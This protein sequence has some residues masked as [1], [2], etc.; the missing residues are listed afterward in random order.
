MSDDTHR[1]GADAG[2]PEDERPHDPQPEAQSPH[3][4]TEGDAPDPKAES[5]TEATEKAEAEAAESAKSTG[6]SSETPT[7][8]SAAAAGDSGEAKPEQS[9]HA[10]ETRQDDDQP[11]PVQDESDY[12]QSNPGCPVVGV[13]ASAG[14]LQAFSALLKRLP[15]NPGFAIVFVQHLSPEHESNLTQILSRATDL[16]VQEAADGTAIE[17]D[18]VYVIPPNRD[19]AVIQGKLQLMSRPELAAQ[20]MPVDYLFRSMADDLGQRAIGVVLSGTGTDG[21][22]GLRAIKAEGGVAIAQ[23]EESASYTGMPHAAMSTGQLDRILAPQAIADELVE[24]ARHPHLRRP[25][26]AKQL[27]G[28]ERSNLLQKVFVLVRQATGVDFSQYKQTTVLRRISRRMLLHKIDSLEAYLSY[29]QKRSAEIQALFDDMLISVTSFF[30]DPESFEALKEEVFPQILDSRNG[31]APVRIWVP[32][33]ST[34]EEAYSLAIALVEYFGKKELHFPIQIFGTDISETSI[35]RAREGYYPESIAGDVSEERLRKFFVRS[36]EGYRVSK[37]IRDLCVFARQNVAK[38]PPF[39]NL[40]LLSCRNLLIYLGP[41]L[42]KRA[43]P[44]FHYALKPNGYLLLGRSETIGGFADLFSPVDREQKIYAKKPS[45][46]RLPPSLGPPETVTAPEDQHPPQPAAAT[47]ARNLEREADRL[48]LHRY[49]PP[50][51]IVDADMEI[52]HFRGQTGRFLEPAPGQASLNLLKMARSG[53]TLEL[54]TMIHEAGKQRQRVRREGLRT[55]FDGNSVVVNVEVHPLGDGASDSLHFLVL[56]EPVEEGPSPPEQPETAEAEAGTG[57]ETTTTSAAEAEAERLREELQQTKATMQS[58]IEDDEATNEELRAANEE[59]QS[60]NEELQ[61]TNEELETAK[62]E[63]QSTNEEL[64][65][66]NTELENQNA[67]ANRAIDDFNN[68]HNAIDIPVILLDSDLRIRRFTPP[69]GRQLGVRVADEGRRIGELRL[70]L[71]VNDLENDVREV[72]STLDT[73]QKDVRTEGG[74]WYSLRMRPYRTSDDRITGAVLSLVDITEAHK[75]REAIRTAQVLAEGIVETVRQPLLVLEEGLRVKVA[76]RAFYQTFEVQREATE[77]RLVYELGDGQWDNAPL[78]R[79]L[80]EI[81]PEDNEIK[82]FE[83]EHDFPE[84]GRK[85]A[86]LDARRIE[87]DGQRPHLILL[88]VREL[89]DA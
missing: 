84:I 46:T 42:Q 58:I 17:C 47:G 34:G 18:H 72:L 21:A 52:L 78:R 79:L 50:G 77:G 24:L 65:T 71:V 31:E 36:G 23:D 12:S 80:E 51:V 69:A 16:P 29:L 10:A 63:L 41:D 6:K 62:E 32:A 83:L 86:V 56:F 67:E 15:S 26:R 87:Q 70:G 7:E 39:S 76:N 57:E 14:G 73:L 37:T 40:D 35:K 9:D 19:L 1:P 85:H 20:H 82:G 25:E 64:T 59:I 68:L 4:S 60:A 88:S 61:S 2:K 75:A 66:L 53:L 81:V 30:R 33:C 5:Q 45:S 48:L 8:E 22:A 44:T 43:I 55:T 28:L 3:E 54:R 13:G 11:A 74:Q 27:R 38:D 89:H 49:A